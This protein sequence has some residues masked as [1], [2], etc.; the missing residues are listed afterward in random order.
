MDPEKDPSK[1]AHGGRSDHV[2]G[3]DGPS[4]GTAKAAAMAGAKA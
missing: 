2:S 3:G 1:D 4:G